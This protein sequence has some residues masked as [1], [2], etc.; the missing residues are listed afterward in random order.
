MKFK[1]KLFATLTAI[2]MIIAPFSVNATTV[3]G[4]ANGDGKLNI[5]DAA[6]IASCL[7]NNRGLSLA[8]DYNDDG[9]INVRDA[10]SI[11]RDLAT[12]SAP[13][14]EEIILDIVNE[15]RAKLGVA[16]LV[17]NATMNKAAAL[18]AQ[19]ITTLFSHTR[20]DGTDCFTVY[21]EFNI[22]YRTAGENIAAGNSTAAATAQQWINSQGHYENMIDPNYTEM[23]VGYAYSAN[24]QYGHY[25]VQIFR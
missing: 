8:A 15:E 10:A 20:P 18:R 21:S 17:L 6:F 7:A 1:R 3:K 25:W 22:S 19:E 13:S 2:L 5:R 12:A 23:G 9:E 4:D 11:G 24:S 14:R 16:P